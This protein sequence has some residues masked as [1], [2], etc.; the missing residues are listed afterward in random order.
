MRGSEIGLPNPPPATA[1][2]AAERL[3]AKVE[4][5]HDERERPDAP[6]DYYYQPIMAAEEI[7]MRKRRAK[8]GAE[9]F[10]KLSSG[11][12]DPRAAEKASQYTSYQPLPQFALV[13]PNPK[14]VWHPG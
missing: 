10:N 4:H 11:D 5:N 8:A 3:E 12:M 13:T 9:A 6:Q 7:S 2:E 1:H 14:P